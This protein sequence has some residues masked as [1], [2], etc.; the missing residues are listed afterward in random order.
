MGGDEVHITINKKR[1]LHR[2]N[3]IDFRNRKPSLSR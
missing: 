2:F 3:F 1:L